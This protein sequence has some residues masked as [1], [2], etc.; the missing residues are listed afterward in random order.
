MRQNNSENRLDS[1]S[2]IHFPG[3]RIGVPYFNPLINGREDLLSQKVNTLVR[4]KDVRLSIVGGAGIGKTAFAAAMARD[5]KVLK[6]FRDGILWLNLGKNTEPAV[7]IAKWA[8]L[9]NID[10]VRNSTFDNRIRAIQR[11]ICQGEFLIVLDDVSDLEN[12][13][14]LSCSVSRC[15][16]IV[17]SDNPEI[18]KSFSGKRHLVELTG[19]DTVTSL[20]LINSVLS[21]NEPPLEDQLDDLVLACEGNPLL[22]KRAA[23]CLKLSRETRFN[24]SSLEG[25]T[26]PS[27]SFSNFIEGLK[28][29]SDERQKLFYVTD[30]ILNILPSRIVTVLYH[31]GA[32]SPEPQIFDCE[33]AMAISASDADEIQTL[34]DLQLI[35]TEGSSFWFTKDI[36]EYLLSQISTEA[37]ERHRDYYVAKMARALFNQDDFNHI[38]CQVKWSSNFCKDDELNLS[39]FE[40]MREDLAENGLWNDY[41]V[42]GEKSLLAAK[43]NGQPDELARVYTSLAKVYSILNQKEKSLEYYQNALNHISPLE[44]PSEKASILN[45]IGTIHAYL[46]QHEKALQF[47]IEARIIID[48]LMD[49]L[50]EAN[51]Y[52]NLGSIE[53][54]LGRIE[55]ASKIISHA[56]DLIPLLGDDELKNRIYFNY[57]MVLYSRG[58]L[59]ESI[60]QLRNVVEIDRTMA[61]PDSDLDKELLS[62]LEKE[63]SMPRYMRLMRRF[64]FSLFR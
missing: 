47:L 6:R 19:L 25:N 49:P 60:V 31:L 35:S 8:R 63:L 52:N 58:E 11:T 18:G 43:S 4:G 45:N 33:A 61:D 32:F 59:D 57:A 2:P 21:N 15:A 36:G 50:L 37:I 28:T 41:L 51:I 10:L 29:C 23:A 1:F 62:F 30:S 9:L 5:P 22:M 40:I 26:T 39:L 55:Q 64:I 46:S 42:L 7:M 3:I 56:V 12:A 20:S 34:V 14:R 53:L 54:T 38:F 16:L 17:I 24:P 48:G 44:N 27:L 13:Y